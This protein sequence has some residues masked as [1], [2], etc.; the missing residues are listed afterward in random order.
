[1][2]AFGGG[3]YAEMYSQ[4]LQDLMSTICSNIVEMWKKVLADEETFCG[5]FVAKI[6]ETDT[7]GG[8]M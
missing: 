8:G 4:K 3:M 2:S 1:M 7:D 6:K 5:A